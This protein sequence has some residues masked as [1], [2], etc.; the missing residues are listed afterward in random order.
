MARRPFPVKHSRRPGALSLRRVSHTQPVWC[1]CNDA[2]RFGDGQGMAGHKEKGEGKSGGKGR[3]QFGT[4]VFQW[5]PCALCLHPI[6]QICRR[7]DNA[8]QIRGKCLVWHAETYQRNACQ[9]PLKQKG[10]DK[11]AP[12]MLLPIPLLRFNYLKTRSCRPSCSANPPWSND[13]QRQSESSVVTGPRSSCRPIQPPG[14]RY[15]C[16]CLS[17][18]LSRPGQPIPYTLATAAILGDL[19]FANN[20]KQNN[21]HQNA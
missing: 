11:F 20:T 8:G 4:R 19:S 12:M 2:R 13:C 6:M 7:K 15:R 16:Q 9:G 10:Q 1:S 3:N 17:H 14:R 5:N 21:T 18:H